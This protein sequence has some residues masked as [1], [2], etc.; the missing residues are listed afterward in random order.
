MEIIRISQ[1]DKVGRQDRGRIGVFSRVL[2]VGRS[3]YAKTQLYERT[4]HLKRIVYLK[5]LRITLEG[6]G[7]K[8]LNYT[9][10]KPVQTLF[11]L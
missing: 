10:G 4:Q 8:P 6:N 9:S 3:G 1:V 7:S 11:N 5:C 2:Q